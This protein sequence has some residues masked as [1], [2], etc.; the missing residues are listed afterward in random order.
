MRD[1]QPYTILPEYIGMPNDACVQIEPDGF[2]FLFLRKSI[3]PQETE[4]FIATGL[5]E[6]KLFA[7]HA[8][9]FLLKFNDREWVRAPCFS[10]DA[11]NA[12]Q[13]PQKDGY[14]FQIALVDTN[15]GYVVS[16]LTIFLSLSFAQKIR[17][18]LRKH[19]GLLSNTNVY[20]RIV[21]FLQEKLSS[22]QMAEAALL[23][24]LAQQIMK[25]QMHKGPTLHYTLLNE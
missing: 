1:L 17:G 6:V 8:I 13:P 11:I 21:R 25:E 7:W 14:N 24:Y 22:E 16:T 9:F 23:R 2:T 18:A 12:L 19:S 4:E 5:I 20:M 10:L 3:T 15:T